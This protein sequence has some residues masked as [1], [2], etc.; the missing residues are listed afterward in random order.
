MFDMSRRD[1]VTLLGG[2]WLRGRSPD[3]R[4]DPIYECNSINSD[5]LIRF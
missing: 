4:S 3:L 1:L 2:A 5:A